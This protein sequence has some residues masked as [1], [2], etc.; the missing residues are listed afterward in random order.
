M[1]QKLADPTVVLII[2]GYAD[3]RGDDQSNLKLS[4]RRAENLLKILQNH[5]RLVNMTRAVGMGSSSLFG[6]RQFEKN[7][8]AEAWLVLP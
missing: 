1:R 7:R 5:G 3:T 4:T 8:I 2:L 6:R